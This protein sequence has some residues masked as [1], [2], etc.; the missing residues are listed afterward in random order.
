MKLDSSPS[1]REITALA[2]QYDSIIRPGRLRGPDS[3]SCWLERQGWKDWCLKQK[4][5]TLVGVWEAEAEAY[6]I[7]RV[8]GSAG[9]EQIRPLGRNARF[10]IKSGTPVRKKWEKYEQRW[11]SQSEE[12]KQSRYMKRGKQSLDALCCWG[13]LP[14]PYSRKPIF[15]ALAV[16][17]LKAFKS[18]GVSSIIHKL[19]YSLQRTYM[20][21]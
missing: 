21:E 1:K 9:G 15:V 13:I 16:E 12:L 10:G 2:G 19:W 8:F 11:Q 6:M 14:Q 3:S 7:E 17:D 20:G 5:M 18:K 4:W